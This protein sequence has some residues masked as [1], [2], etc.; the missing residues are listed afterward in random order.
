MQNDFFN[1]LTDADW[2]VYIIVKNVF[3]FG[4]IRSNDH[5]Y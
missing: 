5:S 1:N 4:S 2:T 3:F